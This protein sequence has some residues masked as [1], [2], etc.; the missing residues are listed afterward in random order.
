MAELV[1]TYRGCEIWFHPAAEI[2]NSPCTV[3]SRFTVARVKQDIDALFEDEPEPEP[4]PTPPE[5]PGKEFVETYRGVHIYWEDA[6]HRYWF[7]YEGV[8]YGPITLEEAHE[9]IDWLIDPPEP[10]EPHYQYHSTYREI[11]IYV[12]WPDGTPFT[13]HFNEV[14]YDPTSLANVKA[15]IDAFLDVPREVTIKIVTT[16]SDRYSRYHGLSV[17][18]PLASTFWTNEPAKIFRTSRYG[19]TYTRIVQVPVGSHYVIYG[20]SGGSSDPWHTQIFANNNLIAEGDVTRSNY[21]RGDF[22]GAEVPPTIVDTTIT[23]TAPPS[24]T[25]EESFDISGVLKETISGVLI[26]NQPITIS[27]NGIEL[28]IV[29]TGVAGDYLMS[30]S[31]QNVGSYTLKAQFFGAYNV[32]ASE[33][34]LRIGI[35]RQETGLF[36]KIALLVGGALVLFASKRKR[37]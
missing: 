32:G 18:Q 21:L 29:S 19:F 30:T 33:S 2:Y 31:I 13:A 4:E 16:T 9:G 28:G 26:A 23:I 22:T 35:G 12:W 15:G 34:T 36:G 6:V 14:W 10:T 1:E 7:E 24:V 11:F 37:G 3:Y 5:I 27:Q 8:P 17:D 25:E 20:N